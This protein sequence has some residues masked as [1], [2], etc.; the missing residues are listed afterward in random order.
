MDLIWIIIILIILFVELPWNGPHIQKYSL[1]N[2]LNNAIIKTKHGYLDIPLDK[3]ICYENLAII[4]NVFAKHDIFCW[5][6]EG[7]AL[8]FTR[9]NDFI[10]HDDDVDLGIYEKDKEKFINCLDTL[11]KY[12][13]E[14]AEIMNNNNFYAIIRKG[15]KVDIDIT[16]PNHNCISCSKAWSR[17]PCEK[18]I[19]YLKF[20]KKEIRGKIYNLP[21]I[22][23]LE[24]L[25][26]KDWKIPKRSKVI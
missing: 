10:T 20:D 23:Y 7:T 22:P 18:I 14:I 1:H 8:G 25:Y 9:E 26:G 15:E 17:E 11:K 13:F 5:L 24:F 19:P 16:G 6:S 2:Y 3:E 12:G 21:K 4:H